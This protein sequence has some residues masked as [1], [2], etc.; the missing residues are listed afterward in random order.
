M[1]SLRKCSKEILCV[2]CKD[3]ECLLSGKAM[4][5]CPKYDCDNDVLYDCDNCTFIKQ[6]QKDYRAK[7]GRVKN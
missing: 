2:D 1:S 5:D 7:E 6:Y 3:E 4:S